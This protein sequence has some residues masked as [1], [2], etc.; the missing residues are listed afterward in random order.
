MEKIESPITSQTEN[1]KYTILGRQALENKETPND[2]TKK[3]EKHDKINKKH[4]QELCHV[5][6]TNK[7]Y[8]Q[9]NNV[10]I[11]NTHNHTSLKDNNP[12]KTWNP[13]ISQYNINLLKH[14]LNYERQKPSYL[15]I[16][17]HTEI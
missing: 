5:T 9:E 3:G 15:M 17:K 4:R 16:I 11:P 14:L 12:M 8:L 7:F 6:K 2:N 13:L 10:N 1:K